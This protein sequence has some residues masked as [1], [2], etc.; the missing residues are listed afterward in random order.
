M[1]RGMTLGVRGAVLRDN[2]VLLV[3]HGYTPGWHL[4]G[5]GVEPGETFEEAL[6]KELLEEGN[7]RV[8]GKPVLH[9]LFQNR[10]A[11]SRDHVAV[12]VVRAFE[13]GGPL[14]PSFEIQEAKFFPLNA[15]PEGTT[16][17]TRKR[18]AEILEGTQPPA[19]W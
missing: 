13:Y 10:N 19:Q 8:T 5:G 9:A 17:S 6:A 16:Q 11:S 7:V 15:L 4:P 14:A 18:L 12:Y 3:R 2:E 1:K